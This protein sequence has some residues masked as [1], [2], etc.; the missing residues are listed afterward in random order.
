VCLT[1]CSC[2]N[3][4]GSKQTHRSVIWWIQLSVIKL[5]ELVVKAGKPGLR[6]HSDMSHRLLVTIL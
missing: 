2:S 5:L 4:D 1:A 6:E 3:L